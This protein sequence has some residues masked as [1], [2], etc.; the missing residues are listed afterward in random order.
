MSENKKA[1]NFEAKPHLPPELSPKTALDP[2]VL[3]E[4]TP[5][6]EVTRL[7]SPIREATEELSKTPSKTIET[8]ISSRRRQKSAKSPTKEE[9][10]DTSLEKEDDVTASK[11]KTKLKKVDET[12]Q[13]QVEHTTTSEIISQDL[14]AIEGVDKTTTTTT[15]RRG[16]K[17][18]SEIASSLKVALSE[19]AKTSK[20]EPQD[21]KLCPNVI[22]VSIIPKKRGRKKAV[23]NIE[24]IVTPDNNTSDKTDEISDKTEIHVEPPKIEP[25]KNKDSKIQESPSLEVKDANELI[26]KEEK[27]VRRR[28]RKKALEIAQEGN[29]EEASK[30]ADL[31]TIESIKEKPDEPVQP[32]EISE[33]A[34][35]LKDKSSVIKQT[36]TVEM[37]EK[38]DILPKKER[39][40]KQTKTNQ[41]KDLK[42]VAES[43]NSN[44]QQNPQ[45]SEGHDNDV[46]DILDSVKGRKRKMAKKIKKFL[47]DVDKLIEIQ[48]SQSRTRNSSLLDSKKAVKVLKKYRKKRR[49][50]FS[51][52]NGNNTGMKLKI[53]REHRKPY[54]VIEKNI[55]NPL[56]L[57][58]LKKPANVIELEE[59]VEQIEN[60][61]INQPE[62]NQTTSEI[63]EI[64]G[65]FGITP[66][67]RGRPSKKDSAKDEITTVDE[68]DHKLEKEQPSKSPSP[69]RRMLSPSN[70]TE[71]SNKVKEEVVNIDQT[72]KP[73][74]ATDINTLPGIKR[75]GRPPKKAIIAELEAEKAM[76]ANIS[77]LPNAVDVSEAEKQLDIPQVNIVNYKVIC[78]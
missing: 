55:K 18:I 28:G 32:Q 1:D 23:E 12:I 41:N 34:E 5:P 59:N 78:F 69:K 45:T 57:K 62:P 73:P 67:K 70:T 47:K 53:T 20:T 31:E 27:V 11:G 56:K 50:T 14:S 15:S 49:K 30:I 22:E 42:N 68:I 39:K 36:K 43:P 17:K 10:N 3:I 21:E 2:I 71:K 16:R 8:P 7:T 24:Q 61:S 58:F 33:V 29:H 51:V 76:M 40:T 60:C 4:K 35:D 6:H 66:K 19:K 13:S 74:E 38:V 9:S 72:I 44:I 63:N 25:E 46:K 75:R 48:E 64:P 52:D 54:H 26:E 77:L 65:N 37:I